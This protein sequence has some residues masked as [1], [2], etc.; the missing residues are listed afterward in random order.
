MTP[1]SPDPQNTPRQRRFDQR[2]AQIVNDAV[3][4]GSL[5]LTDTGWQFGSETLLA[6]PSGLEFTG[7]ELDRLRIDLATAILE[8]DATG[9][10]FATQSANLIFAGPT[11]GGAA[12][13]TFRALVVADLANDLVTYAKLQNTAAA[14][15]LLGRGDSGTG[16]VQEISLG[17]NLVMTGTTLAVV[18]GGGGGNGGGLD[19]ISSEYPPFTPAGIDD[20]FDNGAFSGWTAVNSG[21]NVPTVTEANNVCSLSLPGG[22][23]AEEL[24]AYM[25]SATIGAGDYVEASFRGQGRGQNF[26]MAGLVMADGA[27]YGAGAQVIW[28]WDVNENLW[29]MFDYADYNNATLDIAV[30]AQAFGWGGDML[31]RLVFEG[32]GNFSGWIS[33][34]GVSWINV[35]GTRNPA[36][37]PTHVGFFVSTW[38]GTLPFVW[39]FRYL[40][41]V[42]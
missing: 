7:A 37:T 29:A 15:I 30:G 10:R 40:R 21:S 9:L 11:A 42:A 13:P 5:T 25:K 27:T 22:H 19:A 26:N 1:L 16:D 24:A 39:S 31:M 33:P 4:N 8:L 34:D 2:V 20:E 32:S 36:I 14:S 41:F 18:N 28:A 3:R 6:S 23:A 35:T 38:S 17:S 12:A